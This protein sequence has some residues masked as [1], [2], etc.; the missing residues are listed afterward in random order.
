[1]PQRETGLGR[2]SWP[3]NEGGGRCTPGSGLSVDIGAVAEQDLHQPYAAV[4]RGVVQRRH[5]AAAPPV[6]AANPAQEEREV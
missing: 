5:P 3:T 1:M 6:P 4:R 2:L